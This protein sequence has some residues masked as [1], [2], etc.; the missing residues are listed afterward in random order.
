[1]NH[2]KRS[3]PGNTNLEEAKHDELNSDLWKDN[4][5]LPEVKEKLLEIVDKF[6]K[7]LE[8]HDIKCKANDV[9]IVGS[10]A[11]YN[12][13]ENSDIDLHIVADTKAFGDAEKVAK[14]FLDV[15]R[16]RRLNM[17]RLQKQAT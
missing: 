2:Q 9:I 6:L 3:F 7:G 12:Y 5:L 11:N 15:C 10:N 13:S 1:M 16:M 17:M 14:A 4:E 8:K